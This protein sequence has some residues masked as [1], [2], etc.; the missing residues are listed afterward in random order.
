MLLQAG[1]IG[2]N[3]VTDKATQI[4]DK[5]LLTYLTDKPNLREFF[6]AFV[7][8]M[9]YLLE[10][11]N[12]VYL[13][14]FLENAVGEQLDV[15]GAILNQN[16]RIVLPVINFGFQEA[17]GVIAGMAD[18][19]AP[20]IGGTFSDGDY[21]GGGEA[22][23]TDSQYRRLLLV[24]AS[25]MNKETSSVNQLYYYLQTLFGRAP[26]Y[27]ELE[28]GQV[29]STGKYFE[30]SDAR[31]IRA[32]KGLGDY[33]EIPAIT[34][35]GD[36]SG[37]F[38]FISKD[39]H[40]T[41][42]SGIQQNKETVV[43][44]LNISEIRY[45]MKNSSAA[46]QSVVSLSGNFHD[47]K[48]HKVEFSLVGDT[49]TL[50]VDG[51][52]ADTR[53][54]TSHNTSEIGN[55]CRRGENTG[56]AD[57]AML[58]FK[59]SLGNNLERDYPLDEPKGTDIIYD[60]AN[61]KDGLV[62]NSI[63]SDKDVYELD[64]EGEYVVVEDY[65]DYRENEGTTDSISI[66][67]VILDQ[68]FTI[69]FD[70][71]V[72]TTGANILIG[73][74]DSTSS[75]LFTSGGD[76]T[77]RD[78]SG[79]AHSAGI[80]HLNRLTNI[81]VVSNSGWVTIT[82]NGIKSRL[83]YYPSNFVFNMLG[84]YGSGFN[85]HGSV[86]NLEIS[87]DDVPVRKYAIDDYSN[88]VVNSLSELGD[89][90]V[91]NSSFNNDSIWNTDDNHVIVDG[92]LV[93]SGASAYSSTKQILPVTAGMNHVLYI[94]YDNS[95]TNMKINIFDG[96][97]TGNPRLVQKSL[98]EK[99]GTYGFSFTPSGENVLVYIETLNASQYIAI[100][101]V[102]VKEADGYGTVVNGNYPDWRVSKKIPHYP[103]SPLGI[104]VIVLSLKGAEMA[105]DEVSLANY[106]AKYFVPAGT[107]FTIQLL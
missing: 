39:N 98:D 16:R 80:M 68:N 72:R 82:V 40:V 99:G 10:Q 9:D 18:E 106:A 48:L 30:L 35:V 81:K 22:P 86:S 55:L 15:V 34:I 42:F 52:S 36:F 7:S 56:T 62:I 77:L 75:V 85:L 47:G 43:V 28:Q 46:L 71:I 103:V 104:R 83:G 21:E 97:D 61:G 78:S 67:E 95:A 70:V 23:L 17:D 105:N 107:S 8:E 69:E 94:N 31:Y 13:G 59:I 33:Y 88:I 50:T 37:S 87:S 100:N 54:W 11:T 5:V 53:Q 66:P 92:Q 93:I 3:A 24:R 2:T 60:K 102:S 45:F 4:M 89:E 6:L 101:Y 76:F 84:T 14:R 58:N 19:S 90:L 63:D 91:L 51:V 41:F 65:L 32:N 20:A 73:R 12:E 96:A 79:V 38:D 25:C 57:L 64:S 49:A 26:S 44:D 29:T 27:M 74:A 1:G